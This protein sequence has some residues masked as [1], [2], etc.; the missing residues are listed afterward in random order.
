LGLSFSVVRGT[1]TITGNGGAFLR[2]VFCGAVTVPSSNATLLDNTGLAP[3]A[4]PLPAALCP[5]TGS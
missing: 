2:N 1:T 4:S 3:I 5:G